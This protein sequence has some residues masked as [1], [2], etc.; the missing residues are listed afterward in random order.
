MKNFYLIVLLLTT[1][2]SLCQTKEKAIIIIE[3][4]SNYQKD[5]LKKITYYNNIDFNKELNK[6]TVIDSIN[7]GNGEFM[8]KVTRLY[9][10]D[11][12]MNNMKY[13]YAEVSSE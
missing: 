1:T 9:L 7:F 6:V 8:K 11:L 13:D 3:D 10:D 5:F 12:N 4:I 2:F